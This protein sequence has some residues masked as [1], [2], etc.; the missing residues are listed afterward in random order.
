[1]NDKGFKVVI[2]VDDVL[3][4]GSPEETDTFHKK[5]QEKFECRSESMQVLTPDNPLDY[6]ALNLT[7]EVEQSGAVRYSM[8]QTEGMLH[9]W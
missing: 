1:M 3:C 4:R 6:V 5:L 7:M 9:S 2:W 8:D